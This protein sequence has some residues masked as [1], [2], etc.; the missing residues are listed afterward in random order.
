MQAVKYIDHFIVHTESTKRQVIDEFNLTDNLISVIPHG[1]FSPNYVPHESSFPIGRHIIMYGNN[2]P[3]KGADILID[4][5]QMLSPDDKISVSVEI[6]GATSTEYLELLKSKAIGL[7]VHFIPTFVP[8]EQLY[9]L[10]DQS[11]YIAL[12]YRSISQSGVLLLALHF[13]K[14]LLVSDLEPF[15]ET[16]NGFSD[17]MFFEA[18]NAESLEKLLLRHFNHEIDITSQLIEIKRKRDVYSWRNIAKS[19]AEL[20]SNLI[21]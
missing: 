12:P 2:L 6:V 8:D 15:K 9:R 7:N 4:A 11:D 1:A 10:I 16:L 13:N 5:I 14:P 18:N 21:Q 3:Y 19:T 20:Y 17:D